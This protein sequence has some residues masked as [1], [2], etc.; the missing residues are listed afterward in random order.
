MFIYSWKIGVFVGAVLPLGM[1]AFVVQFQIQ[2][3]PPSKSAKYAQRQ[4]TMVSD[5]IMNH[6]TLASL[7][8][9]EEY[10]SKYGLNPSGVGNVRSSDNKHITKS[11]AIALAVIFGLSQGV[12]AVISAITYFIQAE[13]VGNGKHQKELHREFPDS[14]DKGD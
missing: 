1:I 11:R 4:S 13:E 10:L 5:A 2:F 14:H 3:T 8:Y 12:I 7:A 6:E 9:E